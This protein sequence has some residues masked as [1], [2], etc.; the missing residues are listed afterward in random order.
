M[1]FQIF[2]LQGQGLG[3][4]GGEEGC[5]EWEGREREKEKG[6]GGKGWW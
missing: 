4:E 6:S 5:C 2:G 3:E 1:K